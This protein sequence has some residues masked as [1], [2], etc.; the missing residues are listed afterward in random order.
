MDCLAVDDLFPVISGESIQWK[1]NDKKNDFL[2]HSGKFN[3]VSFN[4]Q[5]YMYLRYKFDLLW[6]SKLK[7]LFNEFYYS[8]SCTTIIT[9]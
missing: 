7:Y 5:F 4:F 3:I 9:T 6:L 1:I 8:Y 2:C